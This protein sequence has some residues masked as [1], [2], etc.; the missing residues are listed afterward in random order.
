MFSHQ[1]KATATALTRL[2]ILFT[3]IIILQ[4]SLIFVSITPNTIPGTALAASS[5]GVSTRS[6]NN[7]GGAGVVIGNGSD[8]PF[9]LNVS[10]AARYGLSSS[11]D[12]PFA[13]AQATGAAWD[14]EEIRWDMITQTGGWEVS[15]AAIRA[16]TAHN[17]NVLILLDYNADGSHTMPSDLTAWSNYVRAINRSGSLSLAGVLIKSAKMTKPTS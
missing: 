7:N 9:G 1:H 13:L 15:D 14:R 12:T 17:I 6:N 16:A 5:A 4:L 2:S 11:M 3:I 8:S 10:A